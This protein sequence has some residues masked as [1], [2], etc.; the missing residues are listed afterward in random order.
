MPVDAT[1]VDKLSFVCS[2]T[3]DPEIQV[4]LH[5]RIIL[6]GEASERYKYK[7][8]YSTKYI[9]SVITKK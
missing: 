2:V 9:I 8:I 3:P 1:P 6:T 7:N 4:D 5:I